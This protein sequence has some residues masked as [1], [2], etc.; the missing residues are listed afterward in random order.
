MSKRVGK[1]AKGKG[2]GLKRAVHEVETKAGYLENCNSVRALPRNE[3][4]AKYC[5]VKDILLIQFL[6]APKR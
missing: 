2:R 1:N 6:Q 3:R 4:Q 5:K